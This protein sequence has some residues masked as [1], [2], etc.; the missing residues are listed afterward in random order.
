MP[1]PKV[2]ARR[3]DD[4]KIH[5]L[6]EKYSGSWK[7][8]YHGVGANRIRWLD[9]ISIES[10]ILWDF[11]LTKRNHLKKATIDELKRKY[12]ELDSVM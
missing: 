3:G 11:T 10:C 5:W 1:D 2:I 12:S 4:L 7:E 8:A 9:N 6:T